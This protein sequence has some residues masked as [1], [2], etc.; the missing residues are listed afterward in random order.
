MVQEELLMV[1]ERH[2]HISA[3]TSLSS[4]GDLWENGRFIHSNKREAASTGTDAGSWVNVVVGLCKHSL[5][6][7]E[8]PMPQSP[9][10]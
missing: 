4:R 9:Y 8:V 10:P 3:V 5:L 1:K 6:I 7:V 2:R